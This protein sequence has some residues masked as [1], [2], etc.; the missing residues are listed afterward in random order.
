MGEYKLTAMARE[1]GLADSKTHI[2]AEVYGPG[3]ENQHVLVEKAS[4]EK[5]LASAGISSLIDLKIN[6][7][8]PVKV[9]VKEVQRD[10]LK[11]NIIH[12]DF[13]K[14]QM[15]KKIT[16]DVAINS[17]GKAPAVDASGGILVKSLDKLTI[18]CL[19][20]DL[21]KS[22]EIDLTQLEELGQSIRVEDLGISDK[23]TVKNDLRD[24][25]FSVIAPRKSK[26]EKAAEAE[27][28]AAAEVPAEGE[29]AEGEAKPEGEAESKPGGEAKPPEAKKD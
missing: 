7:Q 11:D 21:I 10:P 27:A 8:E 19:P 23:V 29:E 4:F 17:I 14:I 2:K 3:I 6:G 12:I 26:A 13:H 22:I 5:V 28:E 25:V 20:A 1:K 18:E 24:V 15:D 9:I 16:A